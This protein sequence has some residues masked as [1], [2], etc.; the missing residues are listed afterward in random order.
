VSKTN[1][2]NKALGKKTRV[3]ELIGS[4]TKIASQRAFKKLNFSERSNIL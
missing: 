2:I 4:C 1:L 3:S